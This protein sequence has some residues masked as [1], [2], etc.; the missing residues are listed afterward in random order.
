MKKNNLV[1]GSLC[2][3]GCEI[4]YGMSCIFTKKATAVAGE[5]PLLGWR[6]FL[7]FA[8]MSLC[9]VL[10]II[11]VNLRGK[12]LRPLLLVALFSPVIYFVSETAGI[13]NTT[14]SES[15]VFLACIPV[16]SLIASTMILHKKPSKWQVA[17]ILTTLMGVSIT[18]FAVGVSSSFSVRG[19]VFLMAAVI[20]YALYAV[21]VDRAADYSE[22]EITYIMLA[23]EA[24]VFVFLS[25]AEG[26]INDSLTQLLT[27]PIRERD[28]LSAILYQRLRCSIVAFFLSNEA[29]AKIGVNRTSS[30]IGVATVVSIVAGA[31]LL[32]E[33]FTIWQAVGAVTIIIG[34]Y[35]AN[36][37]KVEK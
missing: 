1:I 14:A 15:G 35:T 22:V 24:N 30:F 17:G 4:I 20:S 2:A 33:V 19:Y 12:K 23:A 36:M 13:S 25:I 5:L 10:G 11:K 3:L 37:K 34:V 8:V 29:I 9:V 16:A 28:F 31:V 32:Y 18:V 7:A 21:F 6:F 26:I 27:L